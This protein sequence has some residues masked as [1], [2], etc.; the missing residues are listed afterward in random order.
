M[1]RYN[2][3]LSECIL[4][5]LYFMCMY[6]NTVINGEISIILTTIYN[7]RMLLKVFRKM[8]SMIKTKNYYDYSCF[9]VWHK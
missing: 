4:C 6:S 7:I 1:R 5:V 8:L 9:R 3:F 2:C